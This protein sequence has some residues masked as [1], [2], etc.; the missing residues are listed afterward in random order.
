M[1]GKGVF[2]VYA[3]GRVQALPKHIMKLCF[4]SFCTIKDCSTEPTLFS[5]ILFFK[6]SNNFSAF[7]KGLHFTWSFSKRMVHIGWRALNVTKSGLSQWKRRVLNKRADRPRLIDVRK[8][9]FAVNSRQPRHH[10]TERRLGS[11]CVPL[12]DV[13]KGFKILIE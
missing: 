3:K 4:L 10:K 12:G 1:L 13:W 11:A 2:Q 7:D 6:A 8:L 9:F 5:S